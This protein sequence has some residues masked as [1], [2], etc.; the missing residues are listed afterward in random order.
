MANPDRTSASSR[1][2]PV[3]CLFL[4]AAGIA[5]AAPIDL[6]RAGKPPEGGT[7]K[8]SAQEIA[9]WVIAHTA[10]GHDAEFFV[11]LVAQRQ[12]RVRDLGSAGCQPA[13]FGSLPK[14]G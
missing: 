12:C 4:V 9:P 10:D 1:L 13:C 3:L 2:R 7:P 6:P 8:L 14:R 11:V 5:M